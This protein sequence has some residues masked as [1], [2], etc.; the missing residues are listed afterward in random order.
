MDV[1]NLCQRL[2]ELSRT[3]ALRAESDLA[4]AVEL[5]NAAY[6]VAEL[7][8]RVNLPEL[9]AEDGKAARA[10]WQDLG[11]SLDTRYLDLRKALQEK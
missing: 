11:R 4:A 1:L 5:A 6:R 3:T 10:R 7:N 9:A 8:I 2:L